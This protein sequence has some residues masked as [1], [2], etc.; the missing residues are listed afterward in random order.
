MEVPA[1]MRV[2]GEDF[3]HINV[4][5]GNDELHLA[6][7]DHYGRAFGLDRVILRDQQELLSKTPLENALQSE[8]FQKLNAILLIGPEGGVTDIRK[9]DFDDEEKN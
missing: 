2:N 7:L 9:K 3:V 6:L 8:E 1:D 5:Q 4:L